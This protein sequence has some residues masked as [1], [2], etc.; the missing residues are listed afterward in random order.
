LEVTIETE[1]PWRV[2]AWRVAEV[3]EAEFGH[4]A[5]VNVVNYIGTDGSHW[6]ADGDDGGGDA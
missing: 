3:L 2:E 1:A 6:E 5:A 4:V